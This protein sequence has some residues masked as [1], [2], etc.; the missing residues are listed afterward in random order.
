MTSR[1]SLLKLLCF[2]AGSLTIA[3]RAALAILTPKS[4]QDAL[5]S[6]TQRKKAA[7]V[8]QREYWYDDQGFRVNPW[9]TA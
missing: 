6:V 7:L 5:Q 4:N 8:E 2:G 1:R 9:E 3:P